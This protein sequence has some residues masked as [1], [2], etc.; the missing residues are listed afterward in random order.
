MDKRKTTVS[1]TF[2]GDLAA[3]LDSLID[4]DG[5]AAPDLL[6]RLVSAEHDR[7]RAARKAAMPPAEP[8]HTADGG[9]IIDGVLFTPDERLTSLDDRVRR[10]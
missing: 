3:K 4:E 1:T 2:A 5:I 8:V 9:I 6:R 10:P 7:R